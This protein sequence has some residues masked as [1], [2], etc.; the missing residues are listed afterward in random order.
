MD[1]TGYQDLLLHAKVKKENK[2]SQVAIFPITRYDNILNAPKVVSKVDD[3]H[4]PSFMLL[5]TET[6]N[7]DDNIIFDMLNDEW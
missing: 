2:E 3:S 7:V 1:N 5:E 6:E 4:N